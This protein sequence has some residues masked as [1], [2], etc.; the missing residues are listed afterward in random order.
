MLPDGWWFLARSDNFQFYRSFRS[1]CKPLPRYTPARPVSRRWKVTGSFRMPPTMRPLLIFQ[2]RPVSVETD[3]G[4]GI[5]TGNN[6]ANIGGR[7]INASRYARRTFRMEQLTRLRQLYTYKY[8]LTRIEHARAY[9]S[10]RYSNK[11]FCR[12]TS[13]RREDNRELR[14]GI[15]EVI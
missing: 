6:H 14:S 13:F 15:Y 2:M 10:A 4:V 5:H 1:R 3:Q 12:P 7:Q 8:L 11:D 9:R